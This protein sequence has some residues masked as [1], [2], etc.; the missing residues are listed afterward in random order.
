MYTQFLITKHSKQQL[1][2]WFAYV[3]GEDAMNMLEH[4]CCGLDFT[5]V[6]TATAQFDDGKD[7][8]ESQS[9]VWIV[10]RKDDLGQEYADMCLYGEILCDYGG[11]DVGTALLK[12]MQLAETGDEEFFENN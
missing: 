7:G 6:Y 10:V 9:S 2:E 11:I 3:Y 4:K 1:E 8:K 12:L 5:T